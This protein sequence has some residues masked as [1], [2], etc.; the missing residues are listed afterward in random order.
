MVARTYLNVTLNVHYLSCYVVLILLTNGLTPSI[1]PTKRTSESSRDYSTTAIIIIII[2]IIIT[3]IFPLS[4]QCEG[5]EMDA[6]PDIDD[7]THI[8][9]KCRT[10]IAG[11]IRHIN[12]L[13]QERCSSINSTMISS[14]IVVNL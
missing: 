4:L 9:L 1:P 12:C 6:D 10:T 5:N 7:D 11:T 13:L 2:I 14:K 8:C 3:Y